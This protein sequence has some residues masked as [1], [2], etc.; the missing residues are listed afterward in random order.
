MLF[1]PVGSGRQRDVA[2][3]ACKAGGCLEY[4]DDESVKG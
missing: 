1:T 2:S 3:L 4:G